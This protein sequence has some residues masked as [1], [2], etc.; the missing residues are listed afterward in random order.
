VN[1]LMNLRVYVNG[2]SLV[3]IYEDYS[4]WCYMVGS[5]AIYKVRLVVFV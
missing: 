2:G 4:P 5:S 1:M 3:E